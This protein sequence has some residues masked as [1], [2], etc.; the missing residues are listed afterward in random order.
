MRAKT[1]QERISQ[2]KSV[3]TDKYDYSLLSEPIRWNSK[4]SI[5]CPEHGEF[6]TMVNNH[7]RG[8]GCIKCSDTYKKTREERV[9]SAKLIHGDRYD[10]SKWGDDIRA[11][12]KVEIICPE[13]GSFFQTIANHVNHGSGCPHCVNKITRT[14]DKFIKQA[15]DIHG[16]KYGY[17]CYDDVRGISKISIICPEHG[18]F[19][20]TVGAH[21]AGKGC[22]VCGNNSV[23][24]NEKAV[25]YILKADGVF[26]VGVSSRFEERMNRLVSNTPFRFEV[27]HVKHFDTRRDAFLA[28]AEILK[29]F[30]SAGLSGFDGATEWLLGEPCL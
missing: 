8:A 20:Q 11:S 15:S 4:V 21:L 30:Q 14:Y 23:D 2:F 7:L 16:D 5:V 29:S 25:V 12:A 10:Y 19:E 28:E 24:M 26:K 27:A 18:E 6:V 9:M 3:H 1:L 13:H 17:K 22:Q